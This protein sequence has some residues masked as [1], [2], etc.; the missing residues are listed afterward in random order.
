MSSR[1]FYYFVVS[2]FIIC[3]FSLDAAH[4]QEASTGN[5]TIARVKYGGGG[6]WYNDPSAVPNLLEF[7]ERETGLSVADDEAKI[8]LTDEK[9]FSYPLLYITGHGRIRL[10]EVEVTR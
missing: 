8:A 10:T 1:E 5:L 7:L 6:D 3:G 9:L 4:S 2:L